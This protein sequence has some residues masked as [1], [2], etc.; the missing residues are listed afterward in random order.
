MRIADYA[1]SPARLKWLLDSDPSI[2]WQVM[3]DL[4]DADPA[5]I[6]AERARVA[7]KGWGARLLARQFRAATGRAD[8]SGTYD[9]LQSR[10][11]DG[12]RP[13]SEKPTSAQDDRA[14]RKAS[15][16]QAAKNRPYLRGETEPCINGRIL[17]LGAY[18]A[19]PN[20]ALADQL[21]GEQLSDGGWN[22]EAPK[23]HRS[24][25]HTTINVLEG[26][27]AYERAGR[28]SVAFTQARRRGEKYL[29]R[30]R[31]CSARCAP[32]K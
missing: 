27:L 21:L 26:L 15:G 11:T 5:A 29:L 17:G 22:C 28:K 8:A 14:R 6:A 2:R 7:T 16:F 13:R 18:F 12:P 25:F 3:R 32:E 31:P 24:S 19:T 10:R 23:R 30:A 20:D 4:T 1:P 9:A